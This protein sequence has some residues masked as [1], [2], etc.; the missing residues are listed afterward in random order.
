M[1]LD[2]PKRFSINIETGWSSLAAKSE[3][4]DGVISQG[5]RVYFKAEFHM[6]SD[7][8]YY[9]Y[10]YI[11]IPRLLAFVFKEHNEQTAN[12]RPGFHQDLNA[13]YILLGNVLKIITY[14][15]YL[16]ECN[17]FEFRN[18]TIWKDRVQKEI[19]F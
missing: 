1:L 6:R 7:I 13:S 3:K 11:C 5:A 19:R 15:W 14:P 4:V 16:F 17:A 12:W 10:K 2:C 8:T 18:Y 9:I